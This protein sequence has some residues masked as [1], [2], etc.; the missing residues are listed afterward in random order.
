MK[1]I[2]IFMLMFTLVFG[3][4][5]CEETGE[6]PPGQPSEPN[7]PGEPTE[8]GPSGTAGAIAKV[9]LGHIIKT[10]KS[11]EAEGDVLAMGQVDNVIAAVGFDKDGKVV[12]VTIDTAQ[13]SVS[14]DK[15]L[16]VSTDLTAA[17]ETKVE[18][19]DKYG[20]RAASSI[21]KEWY[22]QI[23]ELEK[24]MIGKSVNE[25]KGMKLNDGKPDV[26][27]LTSLVTISVGD[28]IAA[29]ED[30]YNNAIDVAAGAETVG[31]GQ[32][33]SIEGS[34]SLNAA[35]KVNPLVAVDTVMAATA[36][37]K[38]GKVAGTV[39]D[40]AQTKINFDAQGKI[41][42]VADKTKL[43]LGDEYGMRKASS[44]GKEW[45]EQIAEF[46]KWMVGKNVEEIKSLKVTETTVPDIPE[47]AST[48]TIKVGSYIEVVEE[49]YENAK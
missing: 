41:A 4:V 16:K 27:E 13:Q 28:Y 1:K 20:M 35:E 33:I 5:G 43:E 19:G 11:K 45:N 18:R 49:S 48:V 31:L 14:F 9:G 29:V 6:N 36:F 40:M 46:G 8:P 47:L 24:W 2:L 38:D 26:A 37:D 23:A 22:E 12:K 30:A 44:I 39:I 10:A 21:G 17:Q 42:D 34:K 3:F 25:I 32:S 15:D 7:T